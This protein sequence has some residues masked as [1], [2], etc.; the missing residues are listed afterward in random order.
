MSNLYLIAVI[1]GTEIAIRSDCIESV[2][3]IGE[4][5]ET[6]QCD[7]LV[8]GLMALRS[9]VLTLIDCQYAVTGTSRSIGPRSH[10]I[11]VEVGGHNYALSVDSV[12]DVVSVES[13]LVKPVTRL[14]SRW[15]AVS[16]EVAEVDDRVLMIVSP[17]LLLSSRVAMAA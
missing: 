11:I 7:P 10:A 14:D 16:K 5:I 12:R 4:V 1:A 17:E 2:V 8:A 3:T 6:P 9:R 13:E 15:N